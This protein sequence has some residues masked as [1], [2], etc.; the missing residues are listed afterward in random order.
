MIRCCP[1][2]NYNTSSCQDTKRTDT[3]RSVPLI[4]ETLGQIRS[5]FTLILIRNITSTLPVY[6]IES[7]FLRD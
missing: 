7:T 4:G 5:H 1:H 3:L 2:R 6:S